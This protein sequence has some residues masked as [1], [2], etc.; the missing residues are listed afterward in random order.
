MLTIG[1][2]VIEAESIEVVGADGKAV[3]ATL[4]GYDHASGFGLLK[5]VGPLPASPCLSAVRPR[6]RSASRR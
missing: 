4:A 5:L 6:S 2:L 3:P 1:Y